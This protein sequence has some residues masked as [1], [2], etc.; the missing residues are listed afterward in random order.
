MG[1]AVAHT[2]KA[3]LAEIKEEFSG[4]TQEEQP[5]T[6]QQSQKAADISSRMDALQSMF[7]KGN[8]TQDMYDSGRQSLLRKLT[9][10]DD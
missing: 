2:F 10:Q 4:G 7:D 1:E 5:N 9:L 3:M 6:Q 8:I